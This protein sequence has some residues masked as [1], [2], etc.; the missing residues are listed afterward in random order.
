M[1]MPKSSPISMEGDVVED[2]PV[3]Q[4]AFQIGG[5]AAGPAGVELAAIADEDARHGAVRGG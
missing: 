4:V 2:R 3:G 5:Q 1:A